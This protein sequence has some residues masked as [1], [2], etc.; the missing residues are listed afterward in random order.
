MAACSPFGKTASRTHPFSASRGLGLTATLLRVSHIRPALPSS[1]KW[2]YK[3]RA[4]I[5]A[6]ALPQP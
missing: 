5:G 2:F 6:A 1:S 3:S 4:L